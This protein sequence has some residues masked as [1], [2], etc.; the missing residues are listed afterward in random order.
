MVRAAAK[1][2]DVVFACS[3]AVA[4]EYEGGDAPVLVSYPPI[5]DRYGGGDADEFRNRHEIPAGAPI[6]LAAGSITER[7]GQD[8]LIEAVGIVNR[9]RQVPAVCV[10]AGEPFARSQDLEFQRTLERLAGGARGT[11]RLIGFQSDLSDA[12]AAAAVVV[13]PRRDA[14][15]FGRVPCEA[16]LAGCPVVAARTGGVAEV[17][18]DGE[19]ALLV[20]PGDAA[21]TAAAIRKLLDDPGLATALAARGRANVLRRFTDEAAIAVFASGLRL[22][23]V[24]EDD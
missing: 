21:S 3:Q 2:A 7:R 13:N 12:F 24:A 14:E 18:R 10:I 9:G 17:L 19:T 11:V 16:L 4:A 23:A 15:A 8:V 1:R 5:E 6:V 22:L 20:A